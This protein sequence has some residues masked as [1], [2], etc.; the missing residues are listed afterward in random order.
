MTKTLDSTVYRGYNVSMNN[1]LKPYERAVEFLSKYGEKKAVFTA[2]RLI[3]I[4]KKEG[5][6]SNVLYYEDVLTIL[7]YKIKQ[8]RKQEKL[9]K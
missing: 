7:K 4:F 2:T 9:Y 3:E 1:Y 5:N 8:N 6:K